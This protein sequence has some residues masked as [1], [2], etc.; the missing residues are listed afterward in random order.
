MDNAT[1]A[2]LG[3]HAVFRMVRGTHPTFRSCRVRPTHHLGTVRFSEWCV[4]RTLPL[5]DS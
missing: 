3:H 1:H 5:E 2:P 4:G